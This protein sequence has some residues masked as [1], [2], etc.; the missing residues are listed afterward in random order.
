MIIDELLGGE[1]EDDRLRMALAG[2]EDDLVNFQAGTTA[3]RD[4]AEGHAW[5]D[6]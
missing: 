6:L 1:P 3:T 2:L 4:K 5:T